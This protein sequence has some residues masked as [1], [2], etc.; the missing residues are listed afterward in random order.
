MSAACGGGT[1]ECCKG[2]CIAT[3]AQVAVGGQHTCAV[4]TDGSLWC[5][6]YD[7]DGELGD[8]GQSFG[9]VQVTTL[10]S[11]VATV[12]AGRLHTCAVKT[13][14]S[15]WCWGSNYFG[16]LGDGTS[17]DRT[18]PVQ[19]T[20]LGNSVAAV[21]AGNRH[22]CAVKTDGTL[23]CWGDNSH[24]QLGNGTTTGSNVPVQAGQGTIGSLG[25][26]VSA[27]FS[28]TCARLTS[29]TAWCWG[30]NSLGQLGDGTGMDRNSPVAVTGLGADVSAISAG[31]AQTCATRGDGTG[32]CWGGNSSGEVGD[33]TTSPR[34]APVQVITGVA[35]FAAHNQSTCA[36][37]A[38]GTVACSGSN[39]YGEVGN[40][41]LANQLTPVAVLS[42]GSTVTE[43][44]QGS[45]SEHSCAVRGDGTLWCWGWNGWH[46]LGDG[47]TLKARPLPFRLSLGVCSIDSCAD[48]AKNGTETA[49]DCGGSCLSDGLVCADNKTCSTNADC[50]ALSYCKAGIC[51]ST[52]ADGIQ[53]GLETGIDCGGPYCNPC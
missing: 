36:R 35:T 23:W 42:L 39:A 27:G 30:D 37:K 38:D 13:D 40:N 46:Q 32:W 12:C 49:V 18:T 2:G 28:H 26:Q 25:A 20:A 50:S 16:Q 29:A 4:K 34:V 52:C 14:G 15:L 9:P 10:G 47:S 41:S 8:G 44:S 53:D 3:V 19:V 33:G 31:Q 7:N 11:D 45:A 17:T 21:S 48:G 22:T 51:T 1:P 24:G 6:G 43:L 5:W